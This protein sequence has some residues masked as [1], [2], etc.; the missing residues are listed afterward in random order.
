VTSAGAQT[1]Q[2]VSAGGSYLSTND[3]RLLFPVTTETVAVEVTWPD[4]RVD[5]HAEIP[6]GQS[7]VFFPGRWHA[8]PR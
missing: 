6:A 8:V 2:C 3:V 4:G 1:E 7:C 5:Q